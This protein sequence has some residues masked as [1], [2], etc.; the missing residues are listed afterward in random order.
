MAAV[1]LQYYFLNTGA[2]TLHPM[3]YHLQKITT[4]KYDYN[5]N[6]KELF[7]IVNAF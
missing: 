4:A 1:L 2:Y 5:I 7:A 6:N 3:A